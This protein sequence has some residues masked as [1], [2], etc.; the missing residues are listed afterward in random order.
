MQRYWAP[1]AL[2]FGTCQ[3]NYNSVLSFS[4][5]GEGILHHA[6]NCESMQGNVE[7]GLV[8]VVTAICSKKTTFSHNC[9]QHI[10]AGKVRTT[11][12][13]PTA[14]GAEGTKAGVFCNTL[15]AIQLC[16]LAFLL[17]VSC[18]SLQC[19]KSSLCTQLSSICTNYAQEADAVDICDDTKR[20]RYTTYIKMLRAINFHGITN[21][22]HFCQDTMD[23]IWVQLQPFPSA[24]KSIKG[25][26]SIA[27][28][29]AAALQLL[30]GQR[31]SD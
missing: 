9:E 24:A 16:G 13:L 8:D 20:A 3:V 18:M 30:Q 2:D 4:Q 10:T 11:Y 22:H 25:L 29:L 19:A 28:G 27:S 6:Y 14:C 23:S 15:S 5:S 26:I 17:A 12:Q 21:C 31:S 7:E 1:T